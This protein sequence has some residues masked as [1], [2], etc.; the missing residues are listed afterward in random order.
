M[1]ML[2]RFATSTALALIMGVVCF[3]Q[4]YTQTN[5]VSNSAGI[6]PVTDPQFINPWGFVPRF[7]QPVVEL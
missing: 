3:A 5:L 6:A 7:G 1:K 4:H 2:L